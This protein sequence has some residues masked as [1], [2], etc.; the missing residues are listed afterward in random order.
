MFPHSD[1]VSD[2]T[3]SVHMERWQHGI[4]SHSDWSH[5]RHCS[6]QSP[7][8][9]TWEDVEVGAITCL[10][11]G[12]IA[13]F[14]ILRTEIRFKGSIMGRL[15]NAY[16]PFMHSEADLVFIGVKALRVNAPILDDVA[17]GFS[18]VTPSAAKV[19]NYGAAVHQVLWTQRNKDACS[20]LH[21]ALK[22]S[23]RA[24]GPAWATKPLKKHKNIDCWL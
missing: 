13:T 14:P 2:L 6:L 12:G 7:L 20:L 5:W 19:S 23:Q 11:F 10:S 16:G 22:S 3:S 4:H 21:L 18:D 24:E 1:S 9:S 17:V 15:H 8:I